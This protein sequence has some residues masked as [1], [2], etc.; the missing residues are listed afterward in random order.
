MTETHVQVQG[1]PPL[2]G[3]QYNSLQG[4]AGN[5]AEMMNLVRPLTTQAVMDAADGC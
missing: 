5:M 3:S 2:K 4:A 1:G